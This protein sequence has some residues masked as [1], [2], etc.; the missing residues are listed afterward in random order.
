MPPE[1][2]S[3][4]SDRRAEP[5]RPADGAVMLRPE[6][7]MSAP[8]PGRLVDVAGAGFRARHSAKALVSGQIVEFE[9]EGAEGHARVVWTRILGESV[10]SG[11]LILP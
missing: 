8:V 7:L 5:R 3:N 10:E 1:R 4:A 11:F 2:H 9:F 6:G